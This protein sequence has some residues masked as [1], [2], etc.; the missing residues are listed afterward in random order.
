MVP[1]YVDEALTAVHLVTRLSKGVPVTA[2][3][4]GLGLDGKEVVYVGHESPIPFLLPHTKQG[5]EAIHVERF[6]SDSLAR[7]AGDPYDSI[8]LSP[9]EPP[10]FMVARKGD[11]ARVALECTRFADKDRLKAQGLLEPLRQEIRRRPK[12]DFA[13]VAGC[14]VK[15]H[16]NT[17]R[18]PGLLFRNGDTRISELVDTI[19]TLD[20]SAATV[21]DG[22]PP[23]QAPDMV[24]ST[25]SGSAG[26]SATALPRRHRPSPF[27]T[28]FGFEISLA[29]TTRHTAD[30]IVTF[31][32]EIVAKKDRPENQILLI[33]AGGAD[34]DGYL[35]PSEE[36]FADLLIRSL[37]GPLANLNNLEQVILHRWW[38]GDAWELYPSLVRIC[39]PMTG[40]SLFGESNRQVELSYPP[41]TTTLF[42]MGRNDPCLCGSGRKAKFCHLR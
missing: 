7:G 13:S 26:A 39:N 15:V 27:M 36:G 41:V 6:R 10:D 12:S 31:V 21:P 19:A 37:D 11:M 33:T 40:I 34:R 29:I 2:E 22:P 9:S 17:D 23:Q 30:S 16:I 32:R 18:G 38:E 35:H 28:F 20:P 5:M 8:Q 42:R 3:L 25:A 24:R 1:I 14:S 4:A